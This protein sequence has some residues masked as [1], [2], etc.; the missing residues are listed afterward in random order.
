MKNAVKIVMITTSEITISWSPADAGTL[1]PDDLL[2]YDVEMTTNDHNWTVV[3]SVEI[4]AQNDKRAYRY[5][6][7]RL[8][9]GTRYRFRLVVVWLNANKPT[10]SIPGPAT[11]W[12]RTHCGQ[13]ASYL[14]TYLLLP[15]GASTTIQDY[16]QSV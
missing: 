9:P 10:R 2:S 8:I 5:R 3:G 15:P 12:T 13:F 1:S 7:G 14:L 4:S 11:Q 6:I 16:A